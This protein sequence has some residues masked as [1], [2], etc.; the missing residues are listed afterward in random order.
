ME[1][2]DFCTQIVNSVACVL[3]TTL[4]IYILLKIKFER[5]FNILQIVFVHGGLF[6]VLL[7]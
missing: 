5:A 3:V 4:I 1:L 6:V 7:I 2:T